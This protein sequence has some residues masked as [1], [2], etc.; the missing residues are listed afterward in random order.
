MAVI[1][2]SQSNIDLNSSMTVFS[3]KNLEEALRPIAFYLILDYVWTTIRRDLRKRILIVEEAWYLMQN[4][5]SARFIYGIAK[6]ARK[7]YLGLTTVSQDVDDF[8]TSEYGKAVVTNSSIQMLMKQ[9]PAAIDK[10]VETFYLSEGEKRFLLSAGVGEGLFFAGSNHV[11]IKVMASEAENKLITTNPEEIIKLKEEKRK[12]Q[13]LSLNS[14]SARAIKPVYKPYTPPSD[15]D[16]YTTFDDKGQPKE[17]FQVKKIMSDAASNDFVRKDDKVV[18]GSSIPSEPVLSTQGTIDI[19][20][21]SAVQEKTKPFESQKMD[22]PPQT[23]EKPLVKSAINEDNNSA[24]KPESSEIKPS[25][26]SYSVPQ[27]TPKV[28][29]EKEKHL[30]VPESHIPEKNVIQPLSQQNKRSLDNRVVELRKKMLQDNDG[31]LNSSPSSK[32]I[33]D[34]VDEMRQ[35]RQNSNTSDQ[36]SKP[37]NIDIKTSVNPIPS[38][39][40]NNQSVPPITTSPSQTPQVSTPSSGN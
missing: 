31:F 40:P 12:E 16:E 24:S 28:D 6:R 4:N 35:R 19:K 3:T 23:V 38:T 32:D 26:S 34:S 1:F 29:A 14:G 33:M 13:E 22:T 17:E 15:M 18:S 20:S 37:L 11:A 30:N 8:L 36:S 2:D 7:Y 25:S 10:V 39:L 21:D 5:D 9:H 27:N